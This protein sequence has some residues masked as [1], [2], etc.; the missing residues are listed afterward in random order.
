MLDGPDQD[1][2]VDRVFP[3]DVDRSDE[4]PALVSETLDERTGVVFVG[5]QRE[6]TGRYGLV[7]RPM[8]S[9]SAASISSM[10]FSQRR[11][12]SSSSWG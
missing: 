5:D 7:L 11:M 8:Y 12:Y 3:D 4:V 1:G 6:T 9:A 2:L 10:A